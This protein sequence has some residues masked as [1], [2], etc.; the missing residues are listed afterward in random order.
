[1]P[2]I[3]SELELGHIKPSAKPFILVMARDHGHVMEKI[4][5][6]KRLNLPFV[7]VCGEKINHPNVVYREARIEGIVAIPL[8]AS[9]KFSWKAWNSGA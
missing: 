6:L 7:I 8:T 1:M 5:E 2:H 4:L 9:M 3:A